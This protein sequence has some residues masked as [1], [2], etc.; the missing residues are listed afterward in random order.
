MKYR[1]CMNSEYNSMNFK[2][3]CLWGNLESLE[4]KY[5]YIVVSTAD[6]MGRVGKILN[7]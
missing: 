4:N 3:K 6:P 7:F 2:I 5:K 1:P